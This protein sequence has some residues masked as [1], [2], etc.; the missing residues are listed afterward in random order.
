MKIRLSYTEISRLL[1]IYGSDDLQEYLMNIYGMAKEGHFQMVVLYES[2]VEKELFKAMQEIPFFLS[3][4][5]MSKVLGSVIRC[6]I[7]RALDER[8]T[9]KRRSFI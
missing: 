9:L 1:D 5:E 3:I 7:I 2:P 8:N 6:L 4:E